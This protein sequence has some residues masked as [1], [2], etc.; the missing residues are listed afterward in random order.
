MNQSEIDKI[1]YSIINKGTI[2]KF[3]ESLQDKD[4]KYR[5]YLIK[6]VIDDV[7]DKIGYDVNSDAGITIFKARLRTSNLKGPFES[8]TNF[9]SIIK[10]FG[11][12]L[13]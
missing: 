6:R 4:I 2:T 9:E 13:G 12:S 3:L 8:L 5:T 7:C 1:A 11:R 10:H